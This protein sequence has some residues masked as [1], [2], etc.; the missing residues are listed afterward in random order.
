MNKLFN[1]LHW[2][3]PFV[4]LGVSFI[5]PEPFLQ[6]N[7]LYG[8]TLTV[9]CFLYKLH[10]ERVRRES[11]VKIIDY[12][13]SQKRPQI[14]LISNTAQGTVIEFFPLVEEI[15]STD[16]LDQNLSVVK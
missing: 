1:Y 2:I 11:T 7:L 14:K 10:I 3:T 12:L 16:K 4:P 8:L 9:V 13:Q 15:N 6:S 5:V